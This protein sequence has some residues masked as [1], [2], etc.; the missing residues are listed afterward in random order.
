VAVFVVTLWRGVNSLFYRHGE[1]AEQAAVEV[2]Q[3][4]PSNPTEHNISDS[5]SRS[6]SPSSHRIPTFW[7]TLAHY[8]GYN[9]LSS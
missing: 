9:I 3:S 5:G 2:E 6:K 4:L 7:A 1:V 8:K